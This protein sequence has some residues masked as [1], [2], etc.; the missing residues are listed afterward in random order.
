MSIITFADPKEETDPE[1]TA[2]KISATKRYKTSKR[3]C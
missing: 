2:E 1:E 3:A